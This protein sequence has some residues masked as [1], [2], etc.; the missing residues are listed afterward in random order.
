MV[1]PIRYRCRVTTFRQWVLRPRF[2]A[3]LAAG[4][5]TVLG[6]LP[7]LL[8]LPKVSVVACFDSGHALY[9]WVPRTELAG[10]VHCVTAPAPMVSWT[11][12]IGAT[13]LVQLLVLPLLLAAGAILLRGARDW[14]HSAGRALAVAFVQLTELLTP[15]ERPALAYLPVTSRDVGWPSANP[16]RG[17][18]SCH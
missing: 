17:P 12:M 1:R 10:A 5:A 15:A 3:R 4:V 14:A 18:P 8:S 9:E 7:V 6:L 13:L 16:R 11:L 2:G